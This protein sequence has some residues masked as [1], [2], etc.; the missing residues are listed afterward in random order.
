MLIN[1][2]ST[3]GF[4]MLFTKLLNKRNGYTWKNYHLQVWNLKEDMTV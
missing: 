3:K 2:A 4:Q 1:L